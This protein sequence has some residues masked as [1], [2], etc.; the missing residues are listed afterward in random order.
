MNEILLKRYRNNGHQH[1][2]PVCSEKQIPPEFAWIQPH[3]VRQLN[4]TPTQIHNNRLRQL[5]QKLEEEIEKL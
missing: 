5:N 4:L 1:F 2:L 3:A